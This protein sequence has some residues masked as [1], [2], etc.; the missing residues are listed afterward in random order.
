MKPIAVSY[1]NTVYLKLQPY[2]LKSIARRVNEKLSPIYYGP[3]P[4]IERVGEAA[5]RL[6]LPDNCQ[7]HSVFH[8]SLLKRASS[9]VPNVQPLPPSLSE[10][11]ELQVLPESVV[12]WRHSST[13][14]VEVLIKWC[15]LFEFENTWEEA[16]VIKEQFPH[17]HL[18]DKVHKLGGSIDT[19]PTQQVYRR[20]RSR[21]NWASLVATGPS[22]IA[23]SPN[24]CMDESTLQQNAGVGAPS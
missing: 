19:T 9:S 20:D 8:V 5:Y 22:G 1:A 12:K 14:I 18:E 10:S 15:D 17:F 24:S 16:V 3:Y 13:G 7:V 11:W 6:Q 2:R 21:K 23:V 4:I